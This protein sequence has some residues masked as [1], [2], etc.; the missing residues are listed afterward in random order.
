MIRGLSVLFI[1][2]KVISKISKNKTSKISQDVGKK[3][4]INSCIISQ[5]TLSKVI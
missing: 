5:K 3:V 1:D 4:V 2:S